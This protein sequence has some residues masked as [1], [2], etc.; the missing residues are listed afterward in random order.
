MW[1][2]IARTIALRSIPSS[3][4]QRTNGRPSDIWAEQLAGF[5]KN[6]KFDYCASFVVR[7]LIAECLFD[8]FVASSSSI[9]II[10]SWSWNN[11]KIIIWREEEKKKLTV[12]R[13]APN[14]PT[15]QSSRRPIDSGWL[16]SREEQTHSAHTEHARTVRPES[17]KTQ[18]VVYDVDRADINVYGVRSWIMRLSQRL[19]AS[20]RCIVSVIK[21]QEPATHKHA[22]NYLINAMMMRPTAASSL[23]SVVNWIQLSNRLLPLL[24]L[25]TELVL[26]SEND[27]AREGEKESLLTH[28]AAWTNGVC[29]R[30]REWNEE[31]SR[32]KTNSFSYYF[33]GWHCSLRTRLSVLFNI[34]STLILLPRFGLPIGSRVNCPCKV[35][36]FA[37][38]GCWLVGWKIAQLRTQ[39]AKWAKKRKKVD[40]RLS[41]VVE[42]LTVSESREWKDVHLWL[43]KP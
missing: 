20:W 21:Q 19:F 12:S 43:S 10:F 13:S 9:T 42:A 15:F 35:L 2:E 5:G 26:S 22:C 33:S 34:F 23:C 11:N 27:G 31:M 38:S 29:C 36:Q 30:R 37:I 8:G 1:N 16:F 24:L 25:V 14:S 40:E 17:I 7:C 32:K 18:N 28:F 39:E 3:I 41:Q 4:A 6:L